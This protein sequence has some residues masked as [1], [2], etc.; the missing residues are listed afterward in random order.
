[1]L[2]LY[3][4]AFPRQPSRPGA[5]RGQAMERKEANKDQNKDASDAKECIEVPEI[6]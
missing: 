3:G 4:A 5:Q 6:L 2:Q 1:M